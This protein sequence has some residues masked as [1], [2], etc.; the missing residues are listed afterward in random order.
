MTRSTITKTKNTVTKVVTSIECLLNSKNTAEQAVYKSFLGADDGVKPRDI[1]AKRG[2][3]PTTVAAVIRRLKQNNLL[4]ISSWEESE[5][6]R[7][8]AVYKLG[9]KQ[10]MP[11]PVRKRVAISLKAIDAWSLKHKALCKRYDAINKALVP[12]RNM[13]QQRAANLRYLEH[14]QGIR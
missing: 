10:D 11:M 1:A 4:Y 6:K 7:Q 5:N 9:N 13:K 12:A 3:H 14:I 8:L 2:L